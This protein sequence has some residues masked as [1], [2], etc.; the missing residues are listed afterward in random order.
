MTPDSGQARIR[1]MTPADLDLV[2][3]IEQSLKDA[4]HWT[5]AAYLAAMEP[6]GA[7]RR[8]ALVAE[9]QEA[10]VVGF[11]VASV[12][13]PQGELETIAVAAGDQRRG[14]ARRLFAAMVEKLRVAQ[15]TEVILEV[16]ASNCPALAF[17]H[18]QGFVETGRRPRYYADSQ[19]DALL[20]G[21]RLK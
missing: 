3:E 8:I 16:R 9:D 11:A 4:P 2:M 19:E 17:Y 12:L 10:G 15:V 5:L 7:P 13:S 14:V 20:L 18:A 1:R 21:L 6:Q